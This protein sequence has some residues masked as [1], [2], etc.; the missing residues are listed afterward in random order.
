MTVLCSH[1][2]LFYLQSMALEWVPVPCL[3]FLF[4]SELLRTLCH[5]GWA[6]V[7]VQSGLS[8]KC[9]T[10]LGSHRVWTGMLIVSSWPMLLIIENVLVSLFVL[11]QSMV[12]MYEVFIKSPP[13]EAFLLLNIC[14]ISCFLIPFSVKQLSGPEVWVGNGSFLRHKDRYHETSL[15]TPLTCLPGSK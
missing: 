9:P 1:S 15:V 4:I 6:K 5:C 11:I 2:G 12:S 3:L 7:L 10:L 13:W 14:N 8:F